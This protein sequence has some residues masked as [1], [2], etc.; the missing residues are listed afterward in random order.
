MIT[1]LACDACLTVIRVFG[2]AEV[3]DNLIIGHSKWTAG[4]PCVSDNCH[5]FMRRVTDTEEVSGVFAA[6]D[7]T[8]LHVN[9]LSPED[10]FSALCGLGL[11]E[12]IGTQPEV[13]RALLLSNKVR[14]I[15][16]WQAA[17]GRTVLDWLELENGV[18]IHLASSPAGPVVYKITRNRGT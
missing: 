10:A 4:W 7:S 8:L 3:I 14:D 1:M 15:Q 5:E 13:I 18:R 16:N 6:A 12:E 11:P 2:D 17:S 9:E